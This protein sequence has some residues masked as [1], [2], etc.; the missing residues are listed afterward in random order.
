[1]TIA[2]ENSPPP[3]EKRLSRTARLGRMLRG[4][5][6]TSLDLS[7]T[8]MRLVAFLFFGIY[9]LI[10]GRLVYLGLKP[11]PATLR[12][13]AA[14]AVAAARPDLLDRNGEILAADVKTMSVFAEPRRLSDKDEATELLTAT[15]PVDAKQLRERLGSRKGFVWVKREVTPH[16][17]DE[18]FHLGLAGVGLLA[19]NK[20]IYPNGPLAAHVLGFADTDNI[21][22]AGMEKYVDGQGLANLH[23]LGFELTAETLQPIT[24]SLDL[25][26]T[27]AVRDELAK[28]IEHFKAK[29]GA[30]AIMDV[31][32]GEIVALASLPDYDPN[33]SPNIR[34]KELINRLNVGIYEMGSTFKALTIAMA[35]ELGQGQSELAP[36]CAQRAQSRPRDDPRL[37]C[38]AR[39]AHRARGVRAFLEYRHGAHGPRAGGREAQGVPV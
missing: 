16:Q 9:A 10:C 33:G 28:G 23:S 18:V 21:G 6:S 1:M 35:L 24:L 13:A 8:R 11:D 34:D 27:H 2:Y 26:A 39:H 15:L 30:A 7:A 31:N 38:D 4:L 37:S 17:R 20:R 14:D 36:R 29:A 19:E 22:V 5:F 12:R 3:S 32:T 25:K